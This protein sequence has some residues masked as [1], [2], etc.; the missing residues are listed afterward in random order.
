MGGCTCP[1]TSFVNQSVSLNV[2]AEADFDFPPTGMSVSLIYAYLSGPDY[3]CG[4]TRWDRFLSLH[5]VHSSDDGRCCQTRPLQ[6]GGAKPPQQC[7]SIVGILRLMIGRVTCNEE[8]EIHRTA[9]IHRPF[10]ANASVT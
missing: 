4:I 7:I 8:W 6:C 3:S 2:T 1:V 9:A 5:E 10:L